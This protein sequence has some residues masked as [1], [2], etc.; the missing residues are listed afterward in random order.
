MSYKID[1]QPAGLS[2][3]VDGETILAAAIR[4]GIG[5][6]YGCKDGAC[7][8]CKSKLLEGQV[9]H[10]L[11]Q[12][13]AL[14]EAEEAA[15]LILT[16]CATPQSNCVIEARSVPGAGEFPVRKLPVRV[17]SIDKPAPDVAVLKLQ[18]PANM[19]FE[20]HAGQYIEFLLR[21]GARR[22][23]SMANPPHAGPIEASAPPT[24]ELHIRHMPGGLFT[25]QVF[26]TLKPRDILRIEGPFG[27]FFLREDS[28]KPMVLLASGTGLA[29]VK[30]IIEQMQAK[31]LTR[32][33][34]L[35]WGCR[36]KADLYM[37]DWA[38]QAASQ[39]PWLRYV[40]VLSEPLPEDQ[41]SGR[42][43]FVHEVVMTDLPDLSGHQ[44]YACGAPVMVE[45]AHRDFTS[46]C[47]L[48]DEEFYAD[49]FTSEADKH[50]E[51]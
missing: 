9:T 6:P 49:A 11:H 42:T 24:M 15:G 44:V 46:R 1:V 29:P 32:P 4:Q 33:A 7:G 36:R 51:D 40:P 38:L 13:K 10:G 37:H 48:P 8:S 26:S 28:D 19:P 22:S 43:G 34:V 23:Y 47:G 45:A 35:Y 2:F 21:D 17:I 39:L 5:L 14:S 3:E 20:Y 16:C 18:L 31:G 30:A 27:S 12:H 41:W 25:D 50:E